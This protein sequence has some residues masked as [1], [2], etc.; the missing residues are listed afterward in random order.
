MRPAAP[1][2]PAHVRPAALPMTAAL[3]LSLGFPPLPAV[4]GGPR[5]DLVAGPAAGGAPRAVHGVAESGSERVVSTTPRVE[6]LF[7]Q[8]AAQRDGT[9]VVPESSQLR[10]FAPADFHRSFHVRNFLIWEKKIKLLPK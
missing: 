9:G 10:T 8:A 6:S 1:E 2:A 3:C 7:T 4:S 5:S